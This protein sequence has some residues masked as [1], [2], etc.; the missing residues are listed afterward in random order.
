MIDQHFSVQQKLDIPDQM[1][2]VSRHHFIV[3][4]NVLIISITTC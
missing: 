4:F 1:S 3:I 2:M